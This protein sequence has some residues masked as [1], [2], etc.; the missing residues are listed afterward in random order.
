MFGLM[1]TPVIGWRY[2]VEIA[3]GEP[4]LRKVLFYVD[5]HARREVELRAGAQHEG[6]IRRALAVCLEKQVKDRWIPQNN[7]QFRVST[8]ELI[9]IINELRATAAK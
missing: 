9:S 2:T 3:V 8:E 1:G 4:E 5:S 6:L 7:E